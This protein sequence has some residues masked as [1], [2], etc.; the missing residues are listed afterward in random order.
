MKRLTLRFAE[1]KT[2]HV[3]IFLGNALG[4]IAVFVNSGNLGFM[5]VVLVRFHVQGYC[6]LVYSV[7][8]IRNQRQL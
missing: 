2:S 6:D 8:G 3:R 7:I 5:S 1:T 4:L